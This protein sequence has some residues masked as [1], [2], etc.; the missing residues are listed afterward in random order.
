MA[1]RITGHTELIG[2]MAYPI[3]HSSSPAMHNEA[4]VASC[5]AN[6]SLYKQLLE[7][8]T[9]YAISDLF[10]AITTIA[11][12]SIPLIFFLNEKPL[13]KEKSKT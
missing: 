2:L 8:S 5:K 7:Q 10:L 9:L 3:R 12:L 11:F 6:A 4:F 1:E 13:A